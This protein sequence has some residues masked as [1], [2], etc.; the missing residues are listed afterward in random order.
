MEK[1]KAEGTDPSIS[2]MWF[3]NLSPA[4]SYCS[5]QRCRGDCS[6]LHMLQGGG[7]ICIL[8]GTRHS[9]WEMQSVLFLSAP[10]VCAE[11]A[12]RSL[13]GCSICSQ[14]GEPWGKAPL[15]QFLVCAAAPRLL[16]WQLPQLRARLHSP[17]TSGMSKSD[18]STLPS[19]LAGSICMARTPHSRNYAL[20]FGKNPVFKLATSKP[21][22]VWNL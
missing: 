1:Y 18:S 19:A 16:L 8:W 4:L 10:Q 3:I 6:A 21:V 20:H 15:E 7:W 2:V 14:P 5:G 12:A 13:A 11:D 22:V 17:Y 9:A